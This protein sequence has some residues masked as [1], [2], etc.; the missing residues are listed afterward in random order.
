MRGPLETYGYNTVTFGD[1]PAAG[2][3]EVAKANVGEL[4]AHIHPK[5]AKQIED[6]VYVDDGALATE[7]HKEF[8]KMKGQLKPDGK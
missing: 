8:R 5:T 7:S 3:L 1:L 4:G 6:K 2:E